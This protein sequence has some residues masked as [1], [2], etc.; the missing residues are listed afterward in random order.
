MDNPPPIPPRPP[1]Y[2]LRTP[3]NPRL[4]PRLSPQ[5]QGRPQQNQQPPRNQR[6]AQAQPSQ[7][8]TL[9]YPDGSPT[10]LFDQLMAAIFPHLDPQGTGYIRPEVL[11]IFLTLNQFQPDEDLW[12]SNLK[13]N[14]M[15]TPEDI[16]DA[17]LKAACEAWPFDH[18]VVVR[19]PGRTPLPYGGM[20]LLSLRGLTEM[21]AVEHAAEPERG[22]RAIQ[23]VMTR[24]GVWPHLGP[25]P[26][27]C[28]P[29]DMPPQIQRRVEQVRERSI[30]AAQEKMQANQTRLAI[31]AQGRQNALDLLDPPWVRRVYY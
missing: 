27:G 23:A 5:Q 2:E 18:K 15:F 17:E 13:G 16:A 28:L 26:R 24:Y 1:G 31:E 29:A 9:Y 10:P 30:R 4:P 6:P 8:S 12:K 21:M 25:L 22:H 19:N 3:A 14:I 11:S 7:W 20:P